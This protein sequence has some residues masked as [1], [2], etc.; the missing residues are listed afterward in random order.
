MSEER[1]RILQMVAQGK[2]TV[3]EA[4]ELLTALAE[5]APAASAGSAG[6]ANSPPRYL[7]VQVTQDGGDNVNIRVPLAL[8]RAGVR[9]GAVIPKQARDEVDSALKDKGIDFDLSKADPKKIEEL[10]AALSDLTVDV[11]SEE[12]GK[13]EHVRVFCE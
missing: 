2:I 12:G 11:N 7:R 10:V 8:V 5:R 4:D 6:A 13:K 9:L 3:D 1:K